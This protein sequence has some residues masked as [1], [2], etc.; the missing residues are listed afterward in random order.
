M[1]PRSQFLNWAAAAG[2][3]CACWRCTI[4]IQWSEMLMENALGR[5]PIDRRYQDDIPLIPL[6]VF[7]VLDKEVFEIAAPVIAVGLHVGV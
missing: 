3:P 7:E 5:W 2:I 4:A 6:D 1:L